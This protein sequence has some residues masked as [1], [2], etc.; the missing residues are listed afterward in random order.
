MKK[1]LK[2][3]I[4]GGLAISAL[5]F[6]AASAAHRPDPCRIDHDH[7][8]HAANYYN[9][10]AADKYYRAGAYRPSGVTF[11]IRFG[12]HDYDRRSRHHD[13]YD[14]YDDRGRRNGYRGAHRGRGGGRLVNREVYDTRYRARIVLSERVVRTRRGPRLICT[15]DARG[16]QARYVPNRRLHRIA[17]R[18]CSR[19]A[20]IRV[21]T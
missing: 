6:G 9:Y 8:S 13:R 14:R 20:D 10:Y 12:D 2:P 5:G 4:A 18:E 17:R 1:F 3:L 15:V 21:L 16:P 7:R 11:S 19:R